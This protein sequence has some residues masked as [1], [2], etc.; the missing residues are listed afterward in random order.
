MHMYRLQHTWISWEVLFVAQQTFLKD[1]ACY[2]QKY[3]YALGL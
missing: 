3:M 1:K 2:V